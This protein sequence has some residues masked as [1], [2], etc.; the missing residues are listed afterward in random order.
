MRMQSVLCEIRTESSNII[1]ISSM[2]E[3]VDIL[4]YVFEDATLKMREEFC[5]RLYVRPDHFFVS[6]K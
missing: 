1:Q 4:W 5:I 2:L 6:S 3:V